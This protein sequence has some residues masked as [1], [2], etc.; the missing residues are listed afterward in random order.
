MALQPAFSYPPPPPPSSSFYQDLTPPDSPANG[1]TTPQATVKDLR[2]LFDVLE[3]V[4]A[5]LKAPP[6]TPVFQGNPQQ[7]PDM[8]KLGQLLKKFNRD[9]YYPEVVVPSLYCPN[10][11]SYKYKIIES[12]ITEGDGD[13]LDIYIFIIR[14]RVDYKSGNLL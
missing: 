2:H 3:K 6:N 13:T 7:E 4:L 14:K 10:E 12:E 9:R 8:V 5:D 11:K 1:S